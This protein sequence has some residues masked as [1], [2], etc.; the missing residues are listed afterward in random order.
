MEDCWKPLV[1]QEDAGTRR[2]YPRHQPRIF[3]NGTRC[4]LDEYD[5]REYT[6][7]A[8]CGHLVPENLARRRHVGRYHVPSLRSGE[9]L[10]GFERNQG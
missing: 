6:H 8:G 10:K 4:R 9:D 2:S 7:D 1:P 3:T 5:E